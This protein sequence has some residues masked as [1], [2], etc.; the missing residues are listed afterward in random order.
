MLTIHQVTNAADCKKYYSTSDYYSQGQETIGKWG[1]KL[2]ASLGLSGTVDQ[3]GFEHMVDNQRPDGSPLTARTK[4]SRRVAYDFTVSLPKS[5]S[6]LHALASQGE[7]QKL[8]AAFDKAVAGMMAAVEADM[9]TRIR[10]DGMD[11]DRLTGNMA[12]AEFHHTTSRPVDG[13]PPDPHMHRH[14]VCFNCTEDPVEHRIKAGQFAPLKRDGEYYSALFDSIYARQIEA[15]GYHIDR[16]GGKKWEI[17]GIPDSVIATFKKR[18]NEIEDEAVRRGITDALRK[19]ELGAKTRSGKQKELTLGELYIAWI[20]QLTA[21]ER[22]ALFRVYRKEIEPGP[23]VTADEAVSFAI[24]HLS[25]KQ[26]VF[27]ERELVRVALLHGLG[28][29]TAE[30]IVAELPRHGVLGD[31]I[32]GRRMVTTEVLQDEERLIVGLAA[33]G[34]GQADP[35]DVPEGLSR[36][37]L[38]DG[39]WQAVQSLLESTNVV[40]LVEGPAGAGKTTL[41]KAYDEGVRRAGEQVTYLATTAAAVKVLSDDG[42]EANTVA[43]FL[44]DEKMQKAATGGRLVV[45]ETS[46]LGHKDAV[47]LF[48]LVEKND[49][50]VVFVGDPLQH[51]SVSRG[52]LMRLLKQHAGITPFKLWEIMRQKDPA[53]REAATLLSQGKTAEGFTGL[54]KLGWVKER[55]D[56]TRHREMAGEYVQALKDGVDWK[57]ILAIS[58]THAEA[59]AITSEIRGQLREAGMLSGKEREFT[60]LVAVDTSEA[61]RGL[62]STYQKNDILLFHQNAKGGFTKGDRLTVAD[63][64]A[65]LPLSEASKFSVYRPE[66]ISLAVGDVIRFTGTV[67]TRDGKHTLKNGAAHTVTGITTGGTIRLENGWQV[68]KD[69]GLL[70]HGFVETS[71][72]S[73]GRTVKRALLGMSASSGP[74]I[75]QEQIYVSASRAKERMTLYTDDKKAILAAMQ[76]SSQKLAALDIAGNKPAKPKRRDVELRR[77]RKHRLSYLERLRSLWPAMRRLARPHSQTQGIVRQQPGKDIGYGHG[78]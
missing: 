52:A 26:S 77:H 38:N 12:W 15:L 13:A 2:A 73:Q 57:D 18:T 3:A 45:D 16:Q 1:G 40:N 33:S 66:T 31:V 60:R 69:A 70:R 76:R 14:I 64:S 56:D 17:A 68:G 4:E 42:F 32:D 72:G 22:D 62:A 43:R 49:M 75:N 55:D 37:K 59:N 67:K 10:K 50:N 9:Q 39:Q 25:E 41:L 24:A 29:V 44:L 6:V 8:D 71:F 35:I 23:T 34:R 21:V 27:P 11:A 65:S 19:A 74:A 78:L 36:G 58:P 28:C 53:Y 54:D 30:Q 51:A 5:A 63:R 20:G 47:K 61:E 46:L 7:R 48:N